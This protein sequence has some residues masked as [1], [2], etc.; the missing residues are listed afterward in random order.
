MTFKDY[1]KNR[2]INSENITAGKEKITIPALMQTTDVVTITDF[3]FG[4]TKDGDE[5]FCICTYAEDP[6]KYFFASTILL[7]DLK[8]FVYDACGGSFGEAKGA[9][10]AEGGFK[11]KVSVQKSKKGNSYYNWVA[12]TD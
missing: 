8:A 6:G 7:D 12:L 9:L 10:V 1:Q 2:Q 5:E 11:Y 4:R 3:S